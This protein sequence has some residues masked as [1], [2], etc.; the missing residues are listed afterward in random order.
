[1]SGFSDYIVYVDESGD[2][3]LESINPQY[4]VFV[5]AFVIFHKRDYNQQISPAIQDFKFKY[6]GHDMVILHER[7]IRKSEPPFN[8]LQNPAIRQDFL[9][10]LSQLMNDA[11][12]SLVASCI[13]KRQFAGKH[14]LDHNP[15]HYAMRFGLERVFYHLQEQGQRGRKTHIIFEK[16]GAREDEDLELEFRRQLDHTKVEGLADSLD[17]VFADKQTNSAGLQLAD[18]VARPIGR[19]ILNPQQGNRAYEV[20]RGKFRCNKEGKIDGYGLKCYP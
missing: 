14:G 17:I 10:D 16:R 11:P 2:H 3:S 8:L 6:F 20:L 18:M 4:P 5:L 9:G 12:F 7:E 19:H 1:M 13:D 15:Y